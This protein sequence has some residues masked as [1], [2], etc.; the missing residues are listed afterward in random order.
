MTSNNSTANEVHQKPSASVKQRTTEHEQ[1][2]KP[3][4]PAQ[5]TALQGAKDAVLVAEIGY[6]CISDNISPIMAALEALASTDGMTGKD[7]VKRLDS[8]KNLARFG[9]RVAA[10]MENTLDSEREAMQDKLNALEG[11]LS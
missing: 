9:V 2:A 3:T 10:D 5:Y 1:I 8:I 4:K 11:A 7:L 6:S